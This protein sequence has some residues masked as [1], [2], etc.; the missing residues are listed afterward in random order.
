MAEEGKHK[1]LISLSSKILTSVLK[2]CDSP[3]VHIRF[4]STIL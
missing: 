4:E 2:Q 3:D 1:M